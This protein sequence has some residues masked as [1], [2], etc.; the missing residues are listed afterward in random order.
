[1]YVMHVCM[2]VCMHVCMYVCLYVMY[3][4]TVC[5]YVCMHAC[6][7]VCMSRKKHGFFPAFS[8]RGRP[9]TLSF[10]RF[11]A[12][13]CRKPKPAKSRQGESSLGPL[14]CG[15]GSPK[16][17]FSGTSSNCRAVRGGPPPKKKNYVIDVG[18][19]GGGGGG[20]WGGYPLSSSKYPTR[21][22]M[23]ADKVAYVT[24]EGSY[25]SKP[26][27]QTWNPYFHIWPNE[28]FLSKRRQLFHCSTPVRR[29][30]SRPFDWWRSRPSGPEL[31]VA[32]QCF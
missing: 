21:R 15:T 2:Y 13:G 10:S 29:F 25:K 24:L 18:R 3:V 23:S 31:V 7:H 27:F 22:A 6:M 19:G 4:W 12:N 11:S 8:Q 9:E 30:G 1:M 32:L 14:F 17:T 20:G 16:T 26:S 5:M 28:H